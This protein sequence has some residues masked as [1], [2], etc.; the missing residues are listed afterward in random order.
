MPF[1]PS[2]IETAQK[3][4]EP[5]ASDQGRKIRV[6]AIGIRGQAYRDI[7]TKRSDAIAKKARANVVSSLSDLKSEIVKIPLHSS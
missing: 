7:L 5:Y 6:R 4:K 2:R 1:K 3:V